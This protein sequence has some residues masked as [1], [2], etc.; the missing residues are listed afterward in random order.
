MET[1]DRIRLPSVSADRGGVCR[2]VP[3][4]E[5]IRDSATCRPKLAARTLPGTVTPKEPVAALAKLEPLRPAEDR[6]PDAGDPWRRGSDPPDRCHYPAAR[7][8]DQGPEPA[9]L[10]LRAHLAGP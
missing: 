4:G 8:P 7:R 1:G 3:R 2:S 10:A 9:R 5:V 6:R